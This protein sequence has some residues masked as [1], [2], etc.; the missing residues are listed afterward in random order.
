MT[1]KKF[2]QLNKGDTIYRISMT[3]SELWEVKGSCITELEVE[4]IMRSTEGAPIYKISIRTLGGSYI[5]VHPNVSSHI[6]LKDQNDEI[7]LSFDAYATT[8]EEVVEEAQKAISDKMRIIG[9]IK[10]RANESETAL[11]LAD[12]SLDNTDTKEE[13]SL[14]EFASMALS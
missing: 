6:I 2:T 13:Q 7:N 11:I 3:D 5:T 12:A 14:E 4:N 10:R 1:K 9:I 8:K